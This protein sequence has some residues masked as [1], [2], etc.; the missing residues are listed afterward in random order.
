MEQK[1]IINIAYQEYVRLNARANELIDGSFND[2]KFLGVLGGILLGAGTLADITLKYYKIE[3]DPATLS[4]GI[5]LLSGLLFFI[6]AV[7][8][9]RDLLKRNIISHYLY[10]INN[11]E[12]YLR[13]N[14]GKE[15]EKMDIFSGIKTFQTKFKKRQGN[16]GLIFSIITFVPLSLFPALIMQQPERGYYLMI[17]I[18]ILILY[19]L[20]NI[21]LV[22]KPT[23]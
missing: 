20:A 2:F 6:V 13:K 22:E 1:E 23:K 11:Y 14:I 10:Q 18:G 5:F 9:F 17:T 12:I 15:E 7:I 3:T 8:A 19:I 16:L 21:F 4:Q